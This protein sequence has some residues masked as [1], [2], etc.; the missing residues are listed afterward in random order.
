MKFGR[1]DYGF[2]YGAIDITTRDGFGD[3][4]SQPPAT[5]PERKETP[6]NTRKDRFDPTDFEQHKF[7]LPIEDLKF[8]YVKAKH[9]CFERAIQD[10]PE[11][12]RGM[13][14]RSKLDSY[15]KDPLSNHR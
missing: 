10:L 14:P 5:Q 1:E 8:V 11:T 9:D 13:S 2:G 15:R 12:D 6:P 3:V 4:I 7:S